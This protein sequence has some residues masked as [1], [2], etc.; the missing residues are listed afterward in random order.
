[1]EALRG[2]SD[3]PGLRL[4]VVHFDGIRTSQQQQAAPSLMVEALPAVMVPSF[5]KSSLQLGQIV[6][7]TLERFFIFS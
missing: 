7:I 3:N 2:R 4:Q 5:L 6:E 1:M